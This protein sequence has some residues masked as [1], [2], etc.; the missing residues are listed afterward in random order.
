MNNQTYLL[1]TVIIVCRFPNFI[2]LLLHPEGMSLYSNC[3]CLYILK[4]TEILEIYRVLTSHWRSN[5]FSPGGPNIGT[6]FFED[7]LINDCKYIV[8]FQGGPDKSQGGAGPAGATPMSDLLN[9]KMISWGQTDGHRFTYP[10][11]PLLTQGGDVAQ[12]T[13]CPQEAGQ[14][15]ECVHVK[16][17]PLHSTVEMIMFDQ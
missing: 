2:V 4:L 16:N 15:D 8:V 1:C 14:G 12:N 10:A 3:L 11:S 13:M 7:P 9:F 5:T 17:V 6:P